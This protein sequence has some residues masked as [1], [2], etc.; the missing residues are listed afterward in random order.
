[1][2]TV[3]QAQ[4]ELDWRGYIDT[5]LRFAI[6][7]DVPLERSESTLYGRIGGKY[8]PN[9]AAVADVRLTFVERPA[10]QKFAGLT[11]R[12]ALDA[13]RWESDALY[14]EL[15]DLVLDGLDLRMGR[16]RIAWGSADRFNPTSNL[17]A[18]DVED[19]LLFG[20]T[21]ANEMLTLRYRPYFWFGDEDD[22]WFQEFSLEAVLV[23]IFKPAQLP[24]SGSL[25][26]TDSDE[27]VRLA[28]TRQLK[29]LAVQQKDFADAGALLSYD[30]DIDLPDRNIVNSQVGVRMGW[31]LLGVD[32]SISYFRGYEDFPRAEKAIV[33]G[34]PTDV[35]TNLHL[36][37][38]RVQVLGADM[39][40]SLGWLDGVGLWA[41]VGVTFHDDLYVVIEGSGFTG[42][43]GIEALNTPP[44]QEHEAGQFVK[45]VVGMDYT[46]LPWWYLNVQYIHGFI[47]EFG[48]GNLDD[49]I[50]GGM[51]FKLAHDKLTI[52]LFSIISLT[53][54]SFV[55]FPQLII[56]PFS[57]GEFSVG[58]FLYSGLFDGLDKDTK[59]GSPVVGAST[60]FTR[61]RFSF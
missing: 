3:A 18:L 57:G 29:A 42:Y 61:A 50:V 53:D 49:Y 28:T 46:P 17:N 11:D 24:E 2:P 9:L 58:A 15:R 54:T 23:P 5:D 55:L 47:D 44:V 6:E 22:P 40:T 10:P 45:A 34:D 52:R 36:T 14:V 25:G 7:K 33:T 31:N 59:F 43:E 38:P 51:D 19:P 60:V 13:F 48:A 26:F 12:Q 16:Q 35:R 4:L 30:V 27:A 21:L 8:G 32:M 1:L 39:A 56:K 41:E 20:E 37:Y